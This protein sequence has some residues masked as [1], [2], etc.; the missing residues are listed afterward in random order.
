MDRS[1]MYMSAINNELIFT[2]ESGSHMLLFNE[3]LV[4]RKPFKQCVCVF[5]NNLSA[6]LHSGIDKI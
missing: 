1:M 6:K 5:F 4:K 3:R 2:T